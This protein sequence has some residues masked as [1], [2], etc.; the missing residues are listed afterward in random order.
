MTLVKWNSDKRR[1]V[2]DWNGVPEA[3]ARLHGYRGGLVAEPVLI[4][5]QFRVSPASILAAVEAAIAPAVRRL[6]ADRLKGQRAR[7]RVYFAAYYAIHRGRI[8]AR[9]KAQRDAARAAYHGSA[10]T[11]LRL[12]TGYDSNAQTASERPICPANVITTKE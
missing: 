3:V 1:W 9:R 12:I 8:A 11:S 5:P 10:I 6:A 7:R 2:H 4:A